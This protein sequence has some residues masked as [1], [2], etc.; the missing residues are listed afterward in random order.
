MTVLLRDKEWKWR[1][2]WNSNLFVWNFFISPIFFFFHSCQKKKKVCFSFY[3][4]QTLR[5]YQFFSFDCK[6]KI[7]L[8]LLLIFC[9]HFWFLLFGGELFFFLILITI[10]IFWVPDECTC[11]DYVP[12]DFAETELNCYPPDD[13]SA[14][15]YDRWFECQPTQGNMY[16]L[17]FAIQHAFKNVSTIFG[18]N[19]QI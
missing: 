9:L 16:I 2:L 12:E 17:C 10:L 5:K 19:V 14:T 11:F 13:R 15:I 8:N 1:F 4:I 18:W 6:T 7:I 3:P